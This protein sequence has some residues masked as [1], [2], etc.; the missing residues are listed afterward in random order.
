MA[1]EVELSWLSI[2]P[3]IVTIGLAFATREIILSLFLGMASGGVCLYLLTNNIDDLNIINKF[4]LPAM[5]S[6]SYAIL[7]LIY[8]WCLGGIL[9]IWSKTGSATYFAEKLGRKIAK[10]RTSS[11]LFA[12]T[13][14][15]VFHQGGTISTILTGTT[16][17]PIADY[18]RVSH[19]ELS[20]VVDSTASPVATLIPFNAWPLFIGGLV[21]GIVPF[22]DNSIDAYTIY[23]SSIPFN[24]YAIFAL[25][26]TLLFSLDLLPWVGKS[27]KEAIDRARLTGELDRYGSQP[28]M[29]KY[30][31][32]I[33]PIP[34]YKSSLLGFLAPIVILLVFTIVPFTLWKLSYVDSKYANW[35]N[36]AFLL[37]TISVM[38]VAKLR[39]MSIEQLMEGF[40]SGCRQMTLGAMIL[41]L[42]VTLG[43]VAKELRTADYIISIVFSDLGVSGSIPLTL[44]IALPGLLTLL[45]M[46][47]A[48]S[49]GSALG[50]YA[51]VFPLALPLAYS[52]NP[53]LLY[54]QIC[55]GAVLG[56]AVFGDQCSPISDTTILSSMFTGCD[57]MDHV[58]TQLPLSCVAA[59]L[60]ILASTVV[61]M[62]TVI[63]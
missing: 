24:F 10:S 14:G 32:E 60:A 17:K 25:I 27:M 51:V 61:T 55:F 58:K 11:L 50:T 52:L 37:S 34:G 40:S 59:G 62:L 36:E 33:K 2:V 28:I 53:D 47:V 35:T 44:V 3:S 7:L 5:G 48:F 39:G 46:I 13:L 9:G 21:V 22:I 41:G 29:E 1:N 4:L 19:E 23:L 45:C 15:M 38:L 31:D 49:T 16:V 42:A 63:I 12:W 26:M 18:Y 20:Y 54:I 30:M 6:E 8:L 43:L 56:G 57:L